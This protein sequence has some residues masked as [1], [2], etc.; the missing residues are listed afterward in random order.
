MCG[1]VS[2]IATR[3]GEW[4][5]RL[6]ALREP[7]LCAPP[8]MRTRLP[9]IDVHSRAKLSCCTLAV[10]VHG[11]RR[12]IVW[13]LEMREPKLCSICCFVVLRPGSA[14]SGAPCAALV[15]AIVQFTRVPDGT[16]F[17]VRARCCCRP[18]VCTHPE[19]ASRIRT[20]VARSIV[21]LPCKP[22]P[23]W[24]RARRLL[25][26]FASSMLCGSRLKRF[27]PI[28]V[29]ACGPVGVPVRCRWC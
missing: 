6:I 8:G 26:G 11:S 14:P 4:F 1:L 25:H 22:E 7:L 10:L 13:P 12:L 19:F 20:E 9:H 27:A 17:Q 2:A 18:T 28:A 15:P 16:R 24:N 29:P 3:R 5:V 21:L 23:L